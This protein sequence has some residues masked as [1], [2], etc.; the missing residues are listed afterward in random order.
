MVNQ[1]QGLL[2][3]AAT[4]KGGVMSGVLLRGY[5]CTWQ[6]TLQRNLTAWCIAQHIRHPSWT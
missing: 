2:Q 3:R 5:A 1:P 6:E 4:A